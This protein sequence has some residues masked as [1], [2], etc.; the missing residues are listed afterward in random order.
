LTAYFRSGHH[1]TPVIPL[2]TAKVSTPFLASSPSMSSSLPISYG[3]RR[4]SLDD[5]LGAEEVSKVGTDAMP[6]SE[7][8]K[9]S[10]IASGAGDYH[11]VAT[12]EDVF[13]RAEALEKEGRYSEAMEEYQR[14]AAQYDTLRQQR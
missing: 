2:T 14:A 4:K 6:S 7:S 3:V 12:A 11:A 9:T 1:A 13:A 10:D 5:S 8:C